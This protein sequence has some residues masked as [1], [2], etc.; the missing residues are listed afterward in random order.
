MALTMPWEIGLPSITR[1]MRA[2][3]ISS[4]TPAALT[5]TATW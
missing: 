2:A 4:P 5:R 1:L 3:S